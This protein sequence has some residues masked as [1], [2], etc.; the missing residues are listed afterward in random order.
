MKLNVLKSFL[1]VARL[2]NISSAASMLHISQP[3]LSRQ[4]KELEED[5]GST[6]FIRGNK[7]VSLTPEGLLLQRRA[8][9]IVEL[10]E[11]TK[12]EFSSTEENVNGTI[13]IVGGET[14]AFRLLA[15][16]FN[17]LRREYPNIQIKI[18]SGNI[19]TVN[20]CLDREM[21]DFG[22]VIEPADITRYE[23]LRLPSIDRWGVLMRKDSPLAKLDAIKPQDL[24]DVPLINSQQALKGGQLS[25]W[26]K[27]EPEKLNLIASY[28]LLFNASLLVEAG[29]GYALC[30][31]NIINTTGKTDLCFRPLT[32]SLESHIDFIWKKHQVFSKVSKLFL[33][34]VRS[35]CGKTDDSTFRLDL[36][37]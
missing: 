16:T 5:L 19:D 9:K 2:Q 26:L 4:I 3:A 29:I 22:L 30:L 36:T 10:V 34:R 18:F 31:D 23:Y 6:L 28:N 25:S 14:H 8:R 7:S 11:K 13:Y 24:W 32:P 35:K 33:E 21:A 27:I 1:I 17:L 20:E 15:N 12:G 37:A